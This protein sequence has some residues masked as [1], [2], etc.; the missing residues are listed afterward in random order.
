MFNSLTFWVKNVMSIS[1]HLQNIRKS[2]QSFNF[3]EAFS[4][5]SQKTLLCTLSH[6]INSLTKTT[7]FLSFILRCVHYFALDF[8]L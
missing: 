8:D 1:L 2:V 4:N 3:K 7:H 5:F 6:L